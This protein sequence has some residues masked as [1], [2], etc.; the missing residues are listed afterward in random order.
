[1]MC[2]VM[3]WNTDIVQAK[4][5]EFIHAV[6]HHGAVTKEH[7]DKLKVVEDGWKKLLDALKSD[8]GAKTSNLKT[9]Y[10]DVVTIWLEMN[11][12]SGS[13]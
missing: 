10:E 2:T 6:A 9:M 5:N 8:H 11:L 12:F 1:M 4:M 7:A 13:S 3:D